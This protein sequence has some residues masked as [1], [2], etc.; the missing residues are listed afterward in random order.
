MTTQLIP[1]IHGGALVVAA[2]GL[3]YTVGTTAA[4][5]TAL[6]ARSP[7]RRRDARKVL[8]LLLHRTTVGD[9]QPPSTGER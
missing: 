8:A 3:L 7:T 5:V 2:S 4:T 9:N 1:L 6:L